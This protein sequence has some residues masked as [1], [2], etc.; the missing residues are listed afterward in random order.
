M[1]IPKAPGVAQMLKDGA[2]V[3]DISSDDYLPRSIFDDIAA[4]YRGRRSLP[5]H[6]EGIFPRSC[7]LWIF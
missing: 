3:S 1:H 4:R 2:R 7:L 5:V 6:E